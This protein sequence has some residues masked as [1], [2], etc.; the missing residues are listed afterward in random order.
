MATSAEIS[1]T[2][3]STRVR[4]DDV[5]AATVEPVEGAR[6]DLRRP[7]MR[8]CWRLQQLADGARGGGP[9][10]RGASDDPQFGVDGKP[11]HERLRALQGAD[12]CAAHDVES[13]PVLHLH[14]LPLTAAIRLASALRDQALDSGSGHR[15]QPLR[16]FAGIPGRGREVQGRGPSAGELLEQSSAI[17]QRQAARI[18][19]GDGEYVEGRIRRRPLV[20]E[21]RYGARARGEPVLELVEAQPALAPDDGLAVDDDAGGQLRCGRLREVGE[22][23]GEIGA[24]P[25]PQ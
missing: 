19:I 21:P 12:H 3:G 7:G 24:L 2:I 17:A 8:P 6:L 16:R 15:L 23:P 22:V 10:R 9:Q 13:V 11:D 1:T 25:R 20:R 5:A 4:F 14:P 18:L